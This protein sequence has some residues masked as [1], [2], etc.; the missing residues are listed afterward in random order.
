MKNSKPDVEIILTARETVININ[1]LRL[2]LARTNPFDSS[3]GQIT[4]LKSR[5]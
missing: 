2:R 4:Q 3:K 1:K 5:I